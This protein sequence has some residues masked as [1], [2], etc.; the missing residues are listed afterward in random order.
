MNVRSNEPYWLVKNGILHSYPS[1]RENLSCDLLIVGG[2]ITGALM[3]HSCV[4]AGFKTVLIDKKEIANGSTSATTSMLQYEID[5]PLYQLS[6]MI[7]NEDAI[8]SYKACRDSIKEIEKLVEEIDSTCGFETKKSLYF[9]SRKKD[10]NWLKIEYEHRKNAGFE[11]V[12]LDKETIRN[13]YGLVAEGGILSADGASID[14]FCLTHDI[15]NFNV[16]KGLAV[17]DKTGLTEVKYQEA[18]VLATTDTKATITAK[19]IIYCTG[20]ESQAML[21]ETIVKLKSTYVIISEQAKELS[22]TISDTLFWNTESPYL[23]LRG[24]ADDRILVGGEDENFRNSLKRDALLDR[25]R[26]KLVK[27]IH[28]L[29]PELTFIDDLAWCGTF[30]ETK[31]GLPYIGAHPKFKHS[32]FCLGFGGNGI[33]FSIIGA[34]I[35]T[36]MIKGETDLLAHFF[37]FGR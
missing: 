7:G 36:R 34:N 12:W 33:T 27:M 20:Y 1:L 17:F 22:K 26:I 30:G 28:K 32:Y 37:R 5:T 23:Y 19:K 11:V 31:D 24:T 13:N 21:P 4:K 25:K 8:A 14:A 6:K 10:L 29:L 35:I 18:G 2:G 9:A 16:K 3:A 15:L